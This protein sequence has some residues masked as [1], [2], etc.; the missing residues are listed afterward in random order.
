LGELDL[1][2]VTLGRMRDAL[3]KHI[4]EREQ[5]RREI[6]EREQQVR[7]L[8]ENSPDLVARCDREGR[9]LYANPALAIATGLSPA[10]LTG[11]RMGEFSFSAEHV[12]LWQRTIA[13]VFASGQS[14]TVE[15]DLKTPS[16]LRRFESRA[17]PELGRDG[18]IE[19]VLIVSRDITERVAAERALRQSEERYRTLIESA[20]IG[21]LVHQDGH[22]RYANPAA[23][24][25]F[26]YETVAEFPWGSDWIEQVAPAF[27]YELRSQIQAVLDGAHVPPHPGWQI[28]RKDGSHRWVQSSLTRVEWD[29]ADAVLSFIR[30]ITDLRDAAD[31][32]S[33]LEE[34]LREAQ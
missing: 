1:L 34:Q 8:A 33:A 27:R 32:Q 14:L 12:A 16:G 29:G 5:S 28:L 7:A 10:E 26:G 18:A 11:R 25:M 24:Q 17:I 20:I 22:V 21:I 9:Y 4:S 31:R 3:R 13:Q 15:F 19:S 30:D 6:F 23:L 2:S